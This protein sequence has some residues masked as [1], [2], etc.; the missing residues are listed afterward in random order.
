MSA[1]APSLG[2]GPRAVDTRGRLAGIDRWWLLVLAV[3]ALIV[4]MIVFVAKPYAEIWSFIQD[5]IAVTLRI[6]IT[7]FFTILVVGMLGGL[8]RISGNRIVRGVSSL[9]VE[10][11]RGIPLLVWL[12]YIW[13]ALPQVLQVLGKA[14]QPIIPAAGN[15][16]STL[17]IDPFVAAVIGFTVCYGAYM[18]E[19]FRAGIES[20]SKG[21]MEAARSLGMSYAQAMRYI[22]LPQAIRVILPPVGNE[23]VTL[24]KD[25]SLVSVLAVSDLTRRGREYVSRSFLSF[26]TFTMIALIYLLMTLIFTRLARWLE[27]RLTVGHR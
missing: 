12:L 10:V 25:S 6:S 14:L 17:R 4:F 22:I 27:Q 2:P 5:G 7:S 18:T 19:I 21:Q 20:I 9:Y 16:I 1:T 3:L 8:G 11:V 15:F 23:F 13:F 24:L 26:E